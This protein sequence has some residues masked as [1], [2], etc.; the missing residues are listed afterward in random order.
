MSLVAARLTGR[1]LSCNV[2]KF[3]E[4]HYAPQVPAR[5]EQFEADL[6]DGHAGSRLNEGTPYVQENKEAVN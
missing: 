3:T 4:K 2:Q 5:Q 1:S 6:G